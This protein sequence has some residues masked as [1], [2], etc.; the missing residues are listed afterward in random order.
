[1]DEYIKREDAIRVACA[2]V[3]DQFTAVDVAVAIE[4]LPAENVMVINKMEVVEEA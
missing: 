4:S 1:M 2:V 3:K